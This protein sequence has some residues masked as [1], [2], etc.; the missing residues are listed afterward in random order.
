[1]HESKAQITYVNSTYYTFRRGIR[2]TEAQ[3]VEYFEQRQTKNVV[4]AV[5]WGN[6]GFAHT[7]KK[8]IVTPI[9]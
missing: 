2:I 9:R 6:G 4:I 5:L 8:Y 7:S 1:M 3:N